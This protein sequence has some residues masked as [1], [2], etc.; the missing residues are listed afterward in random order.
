[1]SE[2]AKTFNLA[3]GYTY[4][5]LFPLLRSTLEAGISV[6]LLGAPGIGKSTLGRELAAAMNK[7]LIDIRLAQ[8]DPAE[9]GGVYFPNREKGILELFPPAWVKLAGEQPCLIFLDEF[10]A[11]ITKLHQ[12]AAYQIVLEKR[13]GDFQFHPDTVIL[14]AGNREDDNAIVTPL[15]SALN[16][17]FAHFTMRADTAGWLKWAAKNN[18]QEHIMAFVQTYG[19]EVLFCA[20]DTDSFPTPRSWE[21]ASK[22]I[23]KV[24]EADIKRVLAACVGAPMADRFQKYLTI[25]RKVNAAKIIAGKGTVDFRRQPEPSFIYAAIFA[26]AGYLATAKVT[27]QQL[28]NIVKF[29]TSPGISAEYQVLF[30]RQIRNRAP[31]LFDRLK[32]VDSFRYLAGSI[33]TLRST[34]YLS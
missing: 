7:T 9:L 18:I 3:P 27:D 14:A 28:I 22:V 5:Q 6:L 15:S 31:E 24:D 20:A 17:R 1:M 12:A 2:K 32:A 26:V 10:N 8:K 33:V 11:A 30:L 4:E 29:I 13:I 34:L 25:Y 16:N 21:M 19:D 23:G